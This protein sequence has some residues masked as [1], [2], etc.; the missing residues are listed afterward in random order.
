[1]CNFYVM[2]YMEGEASFMTCN[3]NQLR[4]LA[5]TMPADS[6]VPLPPNPL[7][8]E[9]A[10]GHHHHSNGDDPGMSKCSWGDV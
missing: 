5:K 4:G 10:S 1:M 9:Q 3:G 6:L 2:Y 7:L 8:D